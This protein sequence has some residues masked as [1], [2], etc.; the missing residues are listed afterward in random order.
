MS[1]FLPILAYQKIGVAPKKSCLKNEWTS[2]R[3]L[4]KMLTWLTQH[5]YTFITPADLSKKRPAKPVLLA[6]FG[7]YQSFY[8]DVFPLLQA[9]QICATLFVAV[10]TLGT[11]NRWQDPNEE[12]W[13]NIVTPK[14]LTQMFKSGRVQI[15][16]LGLD[17]HPLLE[18]EP[19]WAQQNVKE[20]IYRLEKL[21]KIETCAL[22]F[23]PNSAWNEG[24]ARHLT[25]GLNLPV[26][27][28]QKGFNPRIENPFLRV[29]NPGLFTRFLLWKNQ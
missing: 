16:T 4:K 29:L 13:Q 6:F 9:H 18:E 21:Y 10:E 17:G 3:R 26:V 27:T 7:G 2:L 20:S 23:W 24:R 11:Y 12:P 25:R 8:T 1:D 22:G 14:Q 15:G 5:H 19:T 28:S